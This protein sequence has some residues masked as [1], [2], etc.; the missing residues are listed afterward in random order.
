MAAENGGEMQAG[1]SIFWTKI[2]TLT[3]KKLEELFS[4]QRGF[5]D[6]R[7]KP[8]DVSY[9]TILLRSGSGTL[10]ND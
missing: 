8:H 7:P 10:V 9:V 4:D 3:L 2:C 1:E 6:L 5:T